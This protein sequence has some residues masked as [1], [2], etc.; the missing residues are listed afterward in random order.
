MAVKYY[1]RAEEMAQR[2]VETFKTGD[3]P[4]ILSPIFLRFNYDI[5]CRKWS[6]S[7]QL[8]VALAGF[9]DARTLKQWNEVGRYICKG[10]K[11]FAIFS[12]CT[13]KVEDK[14]GE[15][16]TVLFG[17]RCTPVFGIGQTEVVDSEEWEK[18]NEG[19]KKVEE[20]LD[21]LPLVNV[22]RHLGLTVNSYNA[23]KGS[24]EG[25]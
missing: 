12:P 15:K 25:W 6:W 19:Q 8:L 14:N 5:P 4:E 10:Q 9:N 17:F 23:I 21:T 13:R 2:I 24:A 18:S 3:L 7:N 16:K 11:S 20:C 22:D 1:G